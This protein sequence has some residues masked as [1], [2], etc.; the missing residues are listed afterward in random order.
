MS[1]QSH[2]R[3]PLNSILSSQTGVRVLRELLRHGGELSAPD[4]AVRTGLTRQHVRKAL[5]ALDLTGIVRQVGTAKS[6]LW[7]V[8]RD[9]PLADALDAL[10][11][12]EDER[13]Q[14]VLDAISGA[15]ADDDAILAAWLYGSYARSQDTAS[16]DLD[17][18]IVVPDDSGREVINRFRQRLHEAG[19]RL[20][21]RPSVVEISKADVER[22][23]QGDPWWVTMENDATAVKGGTPRTFAARLTRG[24]V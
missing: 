10:Y 5:G 2:L 12:A 13:H 18:A 22:L 16:S 20:F 14:A 8:R 19:E 11:R 23:C 7:R 1:Q 3:Y 4:I 21:F 17:I 15:A 24:K 6:V 9:H